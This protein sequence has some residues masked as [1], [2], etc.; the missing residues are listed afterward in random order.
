MEPKPTPAYHASNKDDWETPQDFFDALNQEFHFNLDVCATKANAKCA[1]FFSS[2]SNGLAQSWAAR[3]CW[4]NPPYSQTAAW[5]QKAACEAREPDT[6]VVG[7]LAARTDTWAW[8]DHVWPA[9]S[10]IRFL[11]GRLRFLGAPSSAPFPSAVV[12]WGGRCGFMAGR[13]A[14]FAWDWK[15]ANRR[16][17]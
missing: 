5:I 16:P 14:A 6:L 17:R 10:Q 2:Q 9:A 4:M 3:R 8:W 15:L 7:L 12:V 1:D 13:L 11:R